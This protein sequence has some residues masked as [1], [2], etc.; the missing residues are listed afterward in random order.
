MSVKFERHNTAG[1]LQEIRT[2]SAPAWNSSAFVQ[3]TQNSTIFDGGAPSPSTWAALTVNANP[4]SFRSAWPGG[5]DSATYEVF[6]IDPLNPIGGL[7][8]G[9]FTY[10]NIWQVLGTN[11][12]GFSNIGGNM[13]EI[14]VTYAASNRIWVYDYFPIRQMTW[15]GTPQWQEELTW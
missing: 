11:L 12:P 2:F 7:A 4:S 10:G 13:V 6:I 5:P 15:R 3:L 1:S 14:V 8:T 9:A